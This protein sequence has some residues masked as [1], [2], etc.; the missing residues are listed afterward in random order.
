MSGAFSIA[1]AWREGGMRLRCPQVALKDTRHPMSWTKVF[2][3]RGLTVPRSKIL[4][5]RTPLGSADSRLNLLFGID[6]LPEAVMDDSTQ[7]FQKPRELRV[8]S[9][10]WQ[11]VKLRLQA[12]W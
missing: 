3:A 4:T 6:I 9:P 7:S 12:V 2:T 10:I 5:V 1:P 11:M 8:L